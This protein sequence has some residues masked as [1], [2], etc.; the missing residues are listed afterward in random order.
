MM[1]RHLRS[2][3][4]FLLISL[5]L[6]AVGCIVGVGEGREDEDSDSVPTGRVISGEEALRLYGIESGIE[7]GPVEPSSTKEPWFPMQVWVSASIL[8][9]DDPVPILVLPV[10]ADS[11]LGVSSTWVG[12]LEAGSSVMSLSVHAD[13]RTCFVNGNAL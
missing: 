6:F 13:G 9:Y 5:G 7:V 10:Y 3:I 11:E 4:F 1:K 2:L 12:D 8:P